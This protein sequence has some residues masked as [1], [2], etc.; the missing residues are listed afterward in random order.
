[1]AIRTEKGGHPVPEEKIRKRY[2]ETL[3]T[4]QDAIP[5][6]DNLYFIDNSKKQIVVAEKIGSDM[7]IL[8]N[9][10]PNWFISAV[11][12]YFE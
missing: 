11:L 4:I 7:E 8:V 2:F 10:P 3:S 1:V 12:P 5:L 9:N 6:V